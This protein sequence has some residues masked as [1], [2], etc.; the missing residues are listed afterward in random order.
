MIEKLNPDQVAG[1]RDLA[2]KVNELADA[3]NALLDV[4][5]MPKPVK[6]PKV[7]INLQSTE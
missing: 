7:K 4:K 2:V 3:V 1:V 5:E 6:P